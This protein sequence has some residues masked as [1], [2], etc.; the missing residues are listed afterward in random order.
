MIKPLVRELEDEDSGVL[1]I[2]DTIE[3]YEHRSPLGRNLT[4]S[5]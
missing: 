4:D 2:D 3:I 5:Q 1:I